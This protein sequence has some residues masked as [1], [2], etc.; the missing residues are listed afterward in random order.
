MVKLIH[1]I[2]WKGHSLI[3]LLFV[4]VMCTLASLADYFHQMY[5]TYRYNNL[6]YIYYSVLDNVSQVLTLGSICAFIIYLGLLFHIKTICE[7]DV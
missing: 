2:K 3:T 4:L 6:N 1:E 5:W 7:D